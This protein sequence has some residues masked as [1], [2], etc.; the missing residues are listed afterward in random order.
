MAFELKII[1]RSIDNKNV[2]D[3]SAIFK[4]IDTY[5]FPLADII[6]ECQLR[7]YL[8][9]WCGFIGVCTWQ[10]ETLVSRIKDTELKNKEIVIERIE[11]YGKNNSF[12]WT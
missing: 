4:L 9:D 6:F 1:G 2:V 11:K 10:K 3:G 7:N 8:I 12:L 5:G